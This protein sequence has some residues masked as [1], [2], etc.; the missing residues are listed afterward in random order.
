MRSS[1]LSSLAALAATVR[2][3]TVWQS[4]NLTFDA[5]ASTLG[6]FPSNFTSKS[7]ALVSFEA[8]FD[9]SKISRSG[10]LRYGETIARVWT[11]QRKTWP[12]MIL[13]PENATDV[14]TILQFYSA[15]YSFWGNDGFA[16]SMLPIS[17]TYHIQSSLYTGSLTKV[18]SHANLFPL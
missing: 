10:D 16:I 11:Q 1:F 6:L 5:P 12:E 3:A 15:A 18:K 17:S 8:V 13:Y 4:R 7:E 9:S 2:G 14:S